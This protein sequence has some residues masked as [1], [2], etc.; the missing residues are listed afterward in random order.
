M[1]DT[2]FDLFSDVACTLAIFLLQCKWDGFPPLSN[3]ARRSH[4]TQRAADVSP[5]APRR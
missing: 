5:A 3:K 1:T 2:L 4:L